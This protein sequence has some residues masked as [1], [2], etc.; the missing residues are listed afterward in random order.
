MRPRRPTPVRPR[1]RGA[2]VQRRADSHQRRRAP[3]GKESPMLVL[4]RRPNEAVRF[5]GFGAAVRV[6]SVK[7]GLVRLGVEA[8]PG[9]AVLRGELCQGGAT[10]RAAGGPNGLT[11][12][13]HQLR[14][15]LKQT[16]VV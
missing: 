16:A 7:R 13:A 6:L 1:G 9:V 8:P 10:H 3:P 15:R 5:P 12:L 11:L 4:S 14:D 2:T